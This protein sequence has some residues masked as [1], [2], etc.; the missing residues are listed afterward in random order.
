[1][2]DFKTNK[3]KSRQHIVGC[4]KPSGPLGLFFFI[5]KPLILTQKYPTNRR[6]RKGASR[7]PGPP[8]KTF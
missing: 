5:K 8:C 3:K 4:S 1:M 6:G 7:G 2:G